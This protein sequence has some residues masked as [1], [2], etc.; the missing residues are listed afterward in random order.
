MNSPL[1]NTTAEALGFTIPGRSSSLQDHSKKPSKSPI[2]TSLDQSRK[3]VA[4][5]MRSL[6][7]GS[8]DTNIRR[9]QPFDNSRIPTT[10]V[11]D[12]RR[13]T[14]SSTSTSSSTI[15]LSLYRNSNKPSDKRNG[16]LL[17]HNGLKIKTF[18]AVSIPDPRKT[19]DLGAHPAIAKSLP[20]SP[21]DPWLSSPAAPSIGAHPLDNSPGSETKN[22]TD[23][24]A[25]STPSLFL[26]SPS[27]N[28]TEDTTVTVTQPP[29]VTHETIHRHTE[30]VVREEVTRE[31]HYHDSYTHI[32]PIKETVYAP[33][34]HFATGL[35]GK[36]IKIPDALGESLEMVKERVPQQKNGS[37][38]WE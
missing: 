9:G 27:L 6:S 20:E 11:Q 38:G 19:P 23:H 10:Q 31:I 17:G 1:P 5:R 34:Q 32:Q 16:G 3:E 22:I 35:E 4:E 13:P 25:E 18:R 28:R 37:M 36:I 15:P 12:L 24:R 8:Q 29:A 33:T 21:V 26:P 2:K 14:S 7:L 30:H